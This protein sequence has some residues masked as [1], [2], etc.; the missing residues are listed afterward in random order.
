VG[1]ALST[2]VEKPAPPQAAARSLPLKYFFGLALWAAAALFAGVF[3]GVIPLSREVV[4]AAMMA[5]IL[6]SLAGAWLLDLLDRRLS[7]IANAAQQMAA[8]VK[9]VWVEAPRR[10]DISGLTGAFNDMAARMQAHVATLEKRVAEQRVISEHG[11]DAMWV[12]DVEAFRLTDVNDNFSALSGYPRDALIG[13][14]P[15]DV[16]P[17]QQVDGRSTEEHARWI[18]ELALRGEKVVTLWTLR[19]RDGVD[20]PCELRAVHLPSTEGTRICGSL[21][22]IRE[23]LRTERRLAENLRFET[24]ITRLSSVMIGVTRE[25][26]DDAVNDALADIGFFA[27]VDRSY[28]F[29]FDESHA[30]VSCTHEWCAP[31][32]SAQI[33]RLRKVQVAEFPWVEARLLRGEVVHVPR[34][35]Q[36]PP[37]ARAERDEWQSESIQSLL[38]VP[39]SA[40]GQIRG[41]V[42]FDS[43]RDEK[44]WPRESIDLLKIF[45]EIVLSAMARVE[46]EN[47]LRQRNDELAH[48][49]GELERSNEELQ[50]FAYITSH[51]LQEPLRSVGSFSDLLQRRYGAQLDDKGREYLK[52]VGDAAQRMHALIDALLGYS[53]IDSRS[54]PFEPCAMEEL[55]ALAQANLDA[56]IRDGGALLTHEPLPVING[57]ASQLTQLLQNLVGNAIK[58]RGTGAPHVHL[59]VRRD[60]AHWEFGVTDNGIGIDPADVPRLFQIFRRLHNNERYPG[61]GI[62]L[63]ICK[64]IVERHH[65]RIWIE[66]ATAGATF[67]FTL[68]AAA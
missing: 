50:Q 32:V 25:R 45:G 46:A 49:V 40:G 33:A 66:P 43:V 15:M 11:P 12:F 30:A 24:L 18:I 13:R 8:G 36:M 19:S 17:P 26:L 55:L 22:D 6:L 20:I 10:D 42:G 54:R 65:G 51:D 58:F 35:S 7:A 47:A 57:D 14:T 23:R 4:G 59:S 62:G 53:R 3:A 1:A 61:T 48:T 60:G 31:G 64:R 68:P 16:S 63:A 28:I 38:L 67:R 37:E 56:S 52:F 39:L 44:A 2:R 29:L 5:L 9:Q 21:L 34:V 27:G 41:Y